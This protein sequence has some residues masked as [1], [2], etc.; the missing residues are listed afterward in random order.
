MVKFSFLFEPRDYVLWK[1]IVSRPPPPCRMR[2]GRCG[3]RLDDLFVFEQNVFIFDVQF[4]SGSFCRRHLFPNE[5]MISSLNDSENEQMLPNPNESDCGRLPIALIAN[6]LLFLSVHTVD[7]MHCVVDVCHL[8]IAL[9]RESIK[10]TQ[11]HI[12]M[13]TPPI[14]GCGS[15]DFSPRE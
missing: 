1:G 10:G 4:V 12:C 5:V 3:C 14:Y 13:S 6:P 2:A 15:D 7:T 11:L 9:S 8:P